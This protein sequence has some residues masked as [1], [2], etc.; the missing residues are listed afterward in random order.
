MS[1][2]HQSMSRLP[3]ALTMG[4]T[5]QMS[6]FVAQQPAGTQVALITECS[7]SDNLAVA[8]PEITVDG[9]WLATLRIAVG[10]AGVHFSE[11]AYVAKAQGE[12]ARR[13]YVLDNEVTYCVRDPRPGEETQFAPDA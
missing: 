1:P 12:L 8:H 4:S 7:M 9:D 10:E 13:G 11:N 6:H 5:A 3:S 2:H